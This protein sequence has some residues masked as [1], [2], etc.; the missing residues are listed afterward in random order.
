MGELLV[1]VVI[2]VHNGERFLAEA[3]RSVLAQTLADLE[4]IVVDDGSTDTSAGIAGSFPSVRCIR[5][6]NKGVAAAR[7]E[8]LRAARAE[9]IAFLDQDDLWLSSKL[10]RQVALLSRDPGSDCAICLEKFFIEPG[11]ERPHWVRGEALETPVVAF[12]PSALLARRRAFDTVGLF[13]ESYRLASDADW[14]FRARDLGIAIGVVPELLLLRR[15]H[16]DNESHKT[17]LGNAELRRIAQASLLRKRRLAGKPAEAQARGA[18]PDNAA[19]AS[20]QA[21]GPEST[22]P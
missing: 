5:L 11:T 18:V 10:E 21:G 22:E 3:V 12:E 6:E 19:G 4:V 13:D 7:N 1:S 9:R 15:I 17:L 16:G 2:P 8:G 14:F 20:G